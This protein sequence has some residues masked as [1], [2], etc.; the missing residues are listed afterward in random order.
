MH[1]T[2]YLSRKRETKLSGGILLGTLNRILT[3]SVSLEDRKE[4]KDMEEMKMNLGKTCESM[5]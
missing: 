5:H 3:V 1:D 2:D 4:Q